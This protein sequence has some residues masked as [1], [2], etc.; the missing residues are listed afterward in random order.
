MHVLYNNNNTKFLPL[1]LVAPKIVLY[2]MMQN[3]FFQELL[4]DGI[5]MTEESR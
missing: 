2:V 4:D 5:L 3:V 1:L